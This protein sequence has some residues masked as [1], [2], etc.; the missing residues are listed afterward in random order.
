MSLG[1]ALEALLQRHWWREHP[2]ALSQ[3]LRPLAALYGGLARHAARR[4]AQPVP[5]PVV[6]VGNLVAGGAGKTP[7]VIALVRA[8]AARGWTPGVV[9]RGH[10]GAPG[11]APRAVG[12]F[13]PA[14][15]AGDEPVLIR[16][17]TGV[18]VW[19]ARDRPA[20]VRALCAAHPAVDVVVADD[21]LQHAPLPR[22]AEIVVIDE[23]GFGNGLL[24]PA[25]PL[26][27]PASAAA[28]RLILY[29]AP[30]PSTRW[31]GVC[32]E[33]RP[34]PAIDLADWLAGRTDRTQPLPALA[35]RP[36]LAAAGI[37]SPERFF[38][39]LE[40]AGL[41]IERLPL[42]DHHAFAALPWPAGTPEVVVTEKD[43]VKLDPA[44]LVGTRV[45]VVGLDFALP[46]SIV[47]AVAARLPPPA[48]P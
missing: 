31:P 29:N 11:D 48:R 40:A 24:L 22:V 28:G 5:V 14:A 43:A 6:V 9:S 2:S 12:P 16:R 45:W 47:D 18:P 41:A 13:T 36:L 39:M 26:R 32:A 1:A 42:P 30:Q 21:G 46:A 8:L 3:A 10:G 23:R 15:E 34:A 33:R 20:A 27:E 17:R 25:G 19:T 38:S 44:R 35:G 7:T 37:A 4:P